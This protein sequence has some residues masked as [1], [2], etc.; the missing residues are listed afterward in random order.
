MN[1]IQAASVCTTYI[2]VTL[3]VFVILRATSVDRH[4]D[5]QKIVVIVVYVDMGQY[6]LYPCNTDFIVLQRRTVRGLH[7][8]HAIYTRATSM[9]WPD[10]VGKH[11]RK[12]YEASREAGNE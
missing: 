9:V 12:P 5:P 4:I 7:D 1:F 6:H 8:T 3:I 2:F 10:D 11:A